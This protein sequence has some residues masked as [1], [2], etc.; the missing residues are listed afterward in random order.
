[1]R[2]LI[3][4]ASILSLSLVTAPSAQSGIFTR[5]PTAQTRRQS[6]ATKAAV[7][8]QKVSAAHAKNDTVSAAKWQKTADAHMRSSRA[9]AAEFLAASADTSKMT[10]LQKTGFKSQMKLNQAKQE[11]LDKY[12]N[13]MSASLTKQ[14]ELKAKNYSSEKASAAFERAD[15]KSAITELEKKNNLGGRSKEYR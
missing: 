6:H 2:T 5:R 13:Q 15:S 9:A 4:A 1:M 3:F 11:K 12:A 8:Q 14:E 10:P 7:A